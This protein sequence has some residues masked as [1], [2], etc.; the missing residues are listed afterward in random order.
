M[1][2]FKIID[3]TAEV[4]KNYNTILLVTGIANPYP[5]KEHLTKM[6]T[7]IVQLDFPDHHNYSE[8][9]LH[10]VAQIFN[11]IA[12]RNKII[13]TTEKDRMRFEEAN[14]INLLKDLPIY[15]API[16]FEFHKDCKN[17]F[18]Q[19]ILDYVRKNKKHH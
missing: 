16:Q 9:D 14:L 6:C 13:V 7:D 10:K 2:S 5:L 19:Q 11:N 3:N 8:N 15:Y 17:E 18:D 12:T 1:K 4:Q